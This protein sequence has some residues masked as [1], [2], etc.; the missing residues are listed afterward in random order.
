M[1]RIVT[2]FVFE[3]Y[4]LQL[5]MLLKALTGSLVEREYE[6]EHVAQFNTKLNSHANFVRSNSVC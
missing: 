2:I 5:E 4:G 6:Y 1:K 3:I